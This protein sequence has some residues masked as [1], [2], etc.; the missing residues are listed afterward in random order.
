MASSKASDASNT[1]SP[2]SAA[3]GLKP[4]SIASKFSARA[5]ASAV[6]VFFTCSVRAA[7][8]AT[9]T[10]QPA[11][12]NFAST[13]RCASSTCSETLATPPQANDAERP[14]KSGNSA[15]LWHQP[16]FRLGNWPNSTNLYASFVVFESPVVNVCQS[17]PPRNKGG[18]EE[19]EIRSPHKMYHDGYPRGNA[20]S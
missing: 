9:N 13:I 12:L 20:L 16:L 14:T 18:T 6:V 8:A 2:R 17:N 11:T 19:S 4:R 3:S 5:A 15:K 7:N 10:V 1:Q